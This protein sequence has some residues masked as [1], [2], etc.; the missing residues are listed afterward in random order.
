MKQIP[1]GICQ[2]IVILGDFNCRIGLHAKI[3]GRD[4]VGPF[5]DQIETTKMD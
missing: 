1:V 2:H 5:T 3:I 4:L